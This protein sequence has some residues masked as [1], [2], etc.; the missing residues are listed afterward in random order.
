VIFVFDADLFN[1]YG[2]SR[3]SNAQLAEKLIQATLD[4]DPRKV[5]FDLTLA[6]YGRSPSLLALAFTPPF[7]AATLCLLLAAAVTLWRAYQRFGP[8]LA[9]RAARSLSASARWSPMPPRLIQPHAG[10]YI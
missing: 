8:P 6:G 10:G 2:M 5:S 4:G 3:A 9:W 7:L 1:N